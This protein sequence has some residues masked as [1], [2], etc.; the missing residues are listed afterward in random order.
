MKVYEFVLNNTHG[1]HARPAGL[2]VQACSKFQSSVALHKGDVKV[3]GKSMLGI[4]KIA[5]SKGDELKIE[6]EGADESEALEALKQ[7]IDNNFDE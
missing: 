6:I 1:L 4:M 5:A 7:L 2:F 3:N